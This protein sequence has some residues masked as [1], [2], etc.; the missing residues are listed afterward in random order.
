MKQTWILCLL[1][2]TMAT[3]GLA[4]TQENRVEQVVKDFFEVLSEMN[5]SKLDPL[6]TKDFLLLEAGEIWNTDSLKKRMVLPEGMK[7]SRLNKLTF[8]KTNVMNEVAWTSYLNEAKF[9]FNGQVRM[10]RWL[11][12]AVLIRIGNGWKINQL[13]STET[14]QMEDSPKE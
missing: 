11:E 4:Q 2:F 5:A 1:F 7:F 14:P 10:A 12:S 3:N 9:A 8:I 13:H 6:I